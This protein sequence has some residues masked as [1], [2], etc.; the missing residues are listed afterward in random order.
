[1][2]PHIVLDIDGVLAD[3]VGGLCPV[4]SDA[5]GREVLEEHITEYYVTDALQIEP[6]IWA[7]LWEAHEHRLYAESLP[8]PGIHEGL[9]A[10]ASLGRL[11]I[12]TGRPP[13]AEA[14]TREWIVRHLDL[15][16][17]VRFLSGAA[18][19]TSAHHVDY[20]V[21]DY[22]EDIVAASAGHGF[23]MDRPWNRTGAP[24]TVR[25]VSSLLEVARH[26]EADLAR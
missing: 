19:Y 23:I 21:D 7:A 18:K 17:D 8:Y 25:R 12:H 3:F 15:P 26:I 16:V 4:V 24:A 1:M 10:L 14:A 13:Q 22:L 5:L 9:K 11:S 20:F 2:K 6:A